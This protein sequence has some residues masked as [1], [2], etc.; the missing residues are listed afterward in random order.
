MSNETKLHIQWILYALIVFILNGT[1]LQ[2]FLLENGLDEQTVTFSLSVLQ[3]VQMLTIFL[4]SGIIDK[5]SKMG[6]NV[7]EMAA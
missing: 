7:N 5:M 1:L 2:T 4:F 6:Y 3:I